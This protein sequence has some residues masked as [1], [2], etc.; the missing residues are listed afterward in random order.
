GS[1]AAIAEARRS[2]VAVRDDL[3]AVAAAPVEGAVGR[4]SGPNLA[5]AN[6]A[7]PRS[8][9]AHADAALDAM[10][11]HDDTGPVDTLVQRLAEAGTL[12]SLRYLLQAR[13]YVVAG[14]LPA[15][16]RELE[17]AARVTDPLAARLR[18]QIHATYGRL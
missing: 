5:D 11:T 15:A 4:G 3:P 2:P 6:V 1:R 10:E 14:E 18:P 12:P 9:L 13:R 7:D 17:S 16:L 8:A